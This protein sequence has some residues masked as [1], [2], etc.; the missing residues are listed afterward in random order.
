MSPSTLAPP[1]SPTKP[2]I[3]I[4]EETRVQGTVIHLFDQL[5]NTIRDWRTGLAKRGIRG[6]PSVS[7]CVLAVYLSPHFPGR[8]RVFLRAVSARAGS[9]CSAGIEIVRSNGGLHRI[10]LPSKLEAKIRRFV[11][12]FDHGKYPEL[13]VGSRPPQS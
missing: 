6:I 13:V 1:Q 10:H 5:G 11:A 4:S 3:R 9:S 2:A 8:V 7:G 12:N